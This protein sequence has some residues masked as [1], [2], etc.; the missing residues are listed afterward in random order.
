MKKWDIARVREENETALLSLAA[1][2][3]IGTVSAALLYQ[4]GYQKAEQARAFLCKE[5]EAF[6]DPFLLKDMDL[7]VRT[8]EQAINSGEEIVIYGDY[9]VDGVTSVCALYLYLQERGARVSFY[10]PHREKEGYGVNRQAID[11]LLAKGVSLVITVDTGITA[12]DEIAYAKEKGMAFVVTDHHTCLAIL[13]E[14]AAVVNPKR[15]DCSY[16]FKELAGVGVVFKLLC[17]LEAGASC[18]SAGK[19]GE[20]YTAALK[21]ICTEYADLAAVGTIADVMPILDENRLLVWIGMNQMKKNPRI[22]LKALIEAAAPGARLEQKVN[23]SF[24]GYTLAPRLN[25]AGR[26]GSAQKALSLL[27]ST[28]DW[29]AA[30]LAKELCDTNAARQKEEA[31][32]LEGAMRSITEEVDF[33]DT[34]VLVLADDHWH[35]GVIG[36]VASRLTEKYGLPTILISFEGD[37]G[38]GSGR[39]TGGVNLVQALASC[40]DLL[41]QYGGHAQAAGL[42][43]ERANLPAFKKQ[44]NEYIREHKADEYEEV[45]AIDCALMPEEITV[46]NAEELSMLE[47]YGTGNPEPLFVLEDA[48]IAEIKAIGAGKHTKMILEKA[49]VRC[50]GVFFN[51]RLCETNFCAG[52]RV[53]AAFHLSVNDFMKVKTAQMILRGLR[54]AGESAAY[55]EEGRKLY[56]AVQAGSQNAAQ[57][58]LI[59]SRSDFAMIYR[60]VKEEM[61]Y[62]KMISVKKAAQ[63]ANGLSYAKVR[64]IFDIFQEMELIGLESIGTEG[65]VFACHVN[66]M[67]S[68]VDLEKSLIYQK[69]KSGKECD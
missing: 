14:A 66:A 12:I 25:A 27:L 34:E 46:M 53:D 19:Q 47:P 18:V 24:I 64:F 58:D 40:S 48:V 9:D 69:L 56:G 5:T 3:K 28:D 37:V 68:K 23:S 54:L 49:G 16:P 22:G 6:Y 52:D 55:L 4:R 11:A 50:E 20:P 30:V 17:A 26:I 61:Q 21:K 42:T 2:L 38:K 7:A 67:R 10:I 45:L 1:E 57:A 51:L 65:D 32:I 41:Q 59:P 13:P 63:K 39:S 60:I 15:P 35:Q 29:Q 33:S 31:A 43:I 36:I 8:I 62:N 44:L